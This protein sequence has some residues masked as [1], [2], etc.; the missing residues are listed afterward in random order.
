MFL[1]DSR[2]VCER[3]SPRQVV[4]DSQRCVSP[5]ATGIQSTGGTPEKVRPGQNHPA[6][7]SSGP[8]RW[9]ARPPVVRSTGVC[10]QVVPADPT[11][12]QQKSSP[13]FK[14]SFFSG[15]WKPVPLADPTSQ[16]QSV[17][18]AFNPSQMGI[19]RASSQE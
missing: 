9:S 14:R 13:A 11:S 7:P 17:C 6:S 12:P 15:G 19:G 4:L 16:Q 10:R 18:P 5:S 1:A 8:C 2:M 3:A